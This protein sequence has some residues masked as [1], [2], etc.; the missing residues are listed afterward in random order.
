[1]HKPTVYL[2]TNIFSAYWHEGGNVAVAARRLHTRE[3]W[4][5]E[6]QHFVLHVST[7]T[8]NELRAVRFGDKPTA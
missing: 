2:D 4:E 3:W 1:M 5:Q 7:T 6:R 8:I